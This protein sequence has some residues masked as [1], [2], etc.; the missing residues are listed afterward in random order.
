M[1]AALRA[2]RDSG[3]PARR[4][5]APPPRREPGGGSAREAVSVRQPRGT[6]GER[7]PSPFGGV[8]V[9][10]LAIFAGVIATVVGFV[11]G[12]GIAF[13]VGLVVCTLG[14]LEVTAREHLSG[15][16]SHAGLLAAIPAAAVGVVIVAIVGVPSPRAV[17]LLAVVPVYTGAFWLLRRRFLTARQARLVRPPT[18]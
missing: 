4:A 13:A 9:S 10:E 5:V 14:V 15:Y 7:P 18:P 1:A 8:P 12:G 16:R 11:E 6:Y 17:I 2:P 3:D